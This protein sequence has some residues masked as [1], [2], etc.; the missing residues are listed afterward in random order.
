MTM[1]REIKSE[2]K[3]HIFRNGKLVKK[4]EDRNC[5]GGRSGQGGGPEALTNGGSGGVQAG[6]SN[7]GGRG[8]NDGTGAGGRGA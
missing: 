8:R 1:L 5:G 6:G 4:D 2:N 3:Y 7:G